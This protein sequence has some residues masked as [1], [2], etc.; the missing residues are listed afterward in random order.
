[1]NF[2]IGDPHLGHEAIIRLCDRPFASVDV[3]HAE[4]SIRISFTAQGSQDSH[5]RKP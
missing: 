4:R 5:P 3:S 1:M 2:Y